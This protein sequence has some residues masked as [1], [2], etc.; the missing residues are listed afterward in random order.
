MSEQSQPL[1]GAD[2]SALR[3]VKPADLAIRFGFGAAISVVAGLAGIV[4][5]HIVGGMLLAFPAI[6]PATLTLIEKEDG[7]AAAVH[8]VGGAIFGGIGLVAFALV[9]FF[10]F[11]RLPAAA[12]LVA[13]L[14]AWSAV[15]IAFYTL[16]S[17]ERIP[18]PE[19]IRGMA[20]R[21]TDA[22]A[23]RAGKRPPDRQ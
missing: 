2:L 17:K 1:F 7:N 21:T 15:S 13:C 9:G 22:I 6:A 14:L 16:R 5:G 23:S 19:A 4:L 18:L 12:V 11:G 20:P 3:K 8:D 10:L